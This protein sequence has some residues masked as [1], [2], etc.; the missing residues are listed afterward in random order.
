MTVINY[1][2]GQ[3]ERGLTIRTPQMRS[4]M[5][6]LCVFS[7]INYFLN[8]RN[9]P[10]FIQ[11]SRA[12]FLFV[13]LGA[14]G[15]KHETMWRDPIPQDVHNL[16]KFVLVCV[17]FLWSHSWIEMQPNGNRND[18]VLATRARRNLPNLSEL[19]LLLC[20]SRYRRITASNAKAHFWP[21]RTQPDQ[22]INALC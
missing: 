3:I 10:Q 13:H 16:L 17:T 21:N 2:Q 7:V 4:D 20:V 9:S 22:V 8:T 14:K 19:V 6:T 15:D 1:W 12:C 18:T 11:T 5:L